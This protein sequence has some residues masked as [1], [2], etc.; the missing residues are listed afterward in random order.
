MKAKF[1]MSDLGALNFYL[2]I[3]VRQGDKG[4]TLCQSS[5]A[6]SIVEKAGL[7]GCNSCATPMEPKLKLSR[8]SSAPPVDATLYRSL[9]GSLRYLVK[10]LIFNRLHESFYGEANTGTS[11]SC[12]ENYKIHSRNH[13]VWY[14]V[15]KGRRMEGCWIQ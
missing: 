3:E 10:C 14:S 15:W 2:G 9:V 12:E 4:I 8:E 7:E 11:R 13:Q 6:Q 5:Y 1:R